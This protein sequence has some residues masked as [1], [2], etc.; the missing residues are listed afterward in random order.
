MVDWYSLFNNFMQKIQN[1]KLANLVQLLENA[2]YVYITLGQNK[3]R[4]DCPIYFV[5]EDFKNKNH[6]TYGKSVFIL[7]EIASLAR[8][9]NL[10]CQIL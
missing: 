9:L 2:P 10:V 4:L 7:D 6:Q 1:K 8:P 3:C 5:R